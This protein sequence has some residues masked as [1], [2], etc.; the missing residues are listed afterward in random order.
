MFAPTPRKEFLVFR[1]LCETDSAPFPHPPRV[2]ESHVPSQ[3]GLDLSSRSCAALGGRERGDPRASQ[4][5]AARRAWGWA[6]S[7]ALSPPLPSPP[8]RSPHPLPFLGRA[9]LRARPLQALTSEEELAA[10]AVEGSHA[11]APPRPE[12]A[13]GCPPLHGRAAGVS[14]NARQGAAVRPAM[15]PLFSW[16]AKV[17]GVGAASG[18]RR[19]PP[20]TALGTDVPAGEV[21]ETFVIVGSLGVRSAGSARGWGV[22]LSFGGPRQGRPAIPGP[23]RESGQ[24][25]WVVYLV[26]LIH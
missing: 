2:L 23:R 7:A 3:H 16:V 17:G 26:V 15:S 11:R 24:A 19:L 13:P 10:A 6:G 9:V 21:L 20:R 14:G 4:L 18:G 22:R 1:T 12:P 5:P 8:P 25:A